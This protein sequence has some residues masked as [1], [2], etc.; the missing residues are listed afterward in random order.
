MNRKLA[1]TLAALLLTAAAAPTSTFGRTF[2]LLPVAA[3]GGESL[4]ATVYS[5]KEESYS[6]RGEG[7]RVVLEYSGAH[8]TG[9][10][11]HV[12]TFSATV[13]SVSSDGTNV[14][15]G[16]AEGGFAVIDAD[17][18]NPSLVSSTVLGYQTPAAM[19]CD[20][21]YVHVMD[22]STT[23]PS[24]VFSIDVSNPGTP[25][26]VSQLSATPGPLPTIAADPGKLAFPSGPGTMIYNTTTVPF[27]VTTMIPGYGDAL[28][29]VDGHLLRGSFNAL[30]IWNASTPGPP[31][32][33]LP[34]TS[35][36]IQIATEGR[37]ALIGDLST[38]VHFVNWENAAM[39]MISGSKSLAGLPQDPLDIF[40][41]DFA[42]LDDGSS[43]AVAALGT[44]FVELDW[45]GSF[46]SANVTEFRTGGRASDVAH[47]VSTTAIGWNWVG[48][49]FV[50]NLE[51]ANPFWS[52]VPGSFDNVDVIQNRDPFGLDPRASAVPGRQSRPEPLGLIGYAGGGGLGCYS[53]E[54]QFVEEIGTLTE[55]E[56]QDLQIVERQSAVGGTEQIAYV[57]EYPSGLKVY[58]VTD[59]S[60]PAFLGGFNDFSYMLAID[61]KGDLAAIVSFSQLLLVDVANPAS[62][63]FIES[64][65]GMFHDGDLYGNRLV[66]ATETGFQVY[67]VSNPA[68][69]S[70]L[71]QATV[72]PEAT[73]SDIDV[74][75]RNSTPILWVA[76]GEVGVRAYSLADP[77]VPDHVASSETPGS[78]M[79][80]AVTRNRLYVADGPSG[81]QVYSIEADEDGIASETTGVG[82]SIDAGRV[83]PTMSVS[84]NP[85]RGSTSISFDAP[86]ASIDARLD[87]LDVT[88]RR[89]AT[90]ARALRDGASGRAA[91]D[92]RDE[93]GAPLPAGVYLLRLETGSANATQKV[94]LVR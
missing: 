65:P 37:S 49:E 64:I 54:H 33:F 28:A 47:L 23:G 45:T 76:A 69:P 8:G 94:V 72:D 62:P 63:T 88:G 48:A 84:P 32:G 3:R 75:W 79:A 68:A 93:G 6:A 87:V 38:S 29:L 13:R 70:L 57:L 10:V 44:R 59:P 16:L 2:T 71:G 67:D 17:V 15:V 20:F 52:F 43:R 92:G 11:E 35:P 12:F 83:A 58:D 91:W 34:V 31:V 85:F 74:E 27:T 73:V 7:N 22:A 56:V 80:L 81:V 42:T 25:S 9:H 1:R 78:A 30:E 90:L 50:E 4:A 40:A 36:V 21:P 46:S 60:D 18:A 53:I 24:F 77:A 51:T 61:V 14:Y 55:S 5:N 86:G 19:A 39:P 82:G 26:V 41:L 66:A 89:V